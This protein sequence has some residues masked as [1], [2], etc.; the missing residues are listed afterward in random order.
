LGAGGC[1][2]LFQK[3]GNNSNPLD[4]EFLQT[5]GMEIYSP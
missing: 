2:A 1:T 5:S 3:M 4:H